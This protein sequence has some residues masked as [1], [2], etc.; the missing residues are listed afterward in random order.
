MNGL[1][2]QSAHAVE[3]PVINGIRIAQGVPNRAHERSSSAVVD[4]ICPEVES[5]KHA[6]AEKM[7][8][9]AYTRRATDVYRELAIKRTTR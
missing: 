7:V 6:L 9:A 5:V 1:H 3:A 2:I 4:A 8:S